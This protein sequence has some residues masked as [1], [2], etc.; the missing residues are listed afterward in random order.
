[1][2]EIGALRPGTA[3]IDFVT[4]II[5]RHR[6]FDQRLVGGEIFAAQKTALF[7]I[8]GFQLFG[9]IVALGVAAVEAVTGRL[10]FFFAAAAAAMFFVEHAP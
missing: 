9:D 3:L 5:D 10:Q 6:V 7:D 2:A 4:F 1:M 8:E